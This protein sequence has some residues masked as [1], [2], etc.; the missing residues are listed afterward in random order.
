MI[1]G[2]VC[3]S[4][5]CY[6]L[7]VSPARVIAI[8]SHAQDSIWLHRG[9]L[10][11]RVGERVRH[12]RTATYQ[13]IAHAQSIHILDEPVRLDRR[14][15]IA[16]PLKLPSVI[17]FFLFLLYFP[18]RPRA[19]WFSGISDEPEWANCACD[20][21]CFQSR[22]GDVPARGRRNRRIRNAIRTQCSFSYAPPCNSP[23]LAVF[24]ARA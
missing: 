24:I 15:D 18:S 5:V 13:F 21:A 14:R 1:T 16:P 10:L 4:R 3:V 2:P 12:A 20:I 17:F 19:V 7:S 9:A 23:Y 11:P 22:A 8:K 6:N